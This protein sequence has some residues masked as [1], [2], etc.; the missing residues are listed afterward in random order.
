[1][2]LEE[3][4]EVILTKLI[5]N[6][7]M[8]SIN[9]FPSIFNFTS[10][11]TNISQIYNGNK[12]FPYGR[13]RYELT[14]TELLT[15]IMNSI[16]LP[17][18]SMLFFHG[19]SWQHAFSIMDELASGSGKHEIRPRQYC[20]DFGLR[21]FY[22]TNTFETACLWAERNIQPAVVVFI[23][24]NEYIEGLHNHLKLNDIREWKE[25]VF[26]ITSGTGECHR[27][28]PR[29]EHSNKQQR[30]EYKK[31]IREIDSQDLISGPILANPIARDVSEVKYIK[32]GN[33]IPTQYSFVAK[34]GPKGKDSTIDDLNGMLVITVFF[35]EII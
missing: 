9:G 35:E 22:L 12:W 20:T 17:N 14:Y 8:E 24:P 29:H 1:M 13:S 6:N 5:T 2:L 15:R 32:Y 28:P 21:N 11:Q 30:N 19:T 10:N 18:N 34:P 33:Y 27:N 31:Y 7:A 26:K 25:T 3:A 16:N 23:I 4:L